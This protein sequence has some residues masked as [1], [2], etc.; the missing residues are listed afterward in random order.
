MQCVRQGVTQPEFGVFWTSKLKWRSSFCAFTVW[1]G[2]STTDAATVAGPASGD[3]NAPETAPGVAVQRSAAR[4][5]WVADDAHTWTCVPDD[6]PHECGR[7]RQ[8]DVL[9]CANMIDNTVHA[10]LNRGARKPMFRNG[11]RHCRTHH[12]PFDVPRADHPNWV[13]SVENVRKHLAQRTQQTSTDSQPTHDGLH[14][15]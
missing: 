13:H 10:L 14:P 8:R 12:D 11:Y 6:T 9:A 3:G 1:K 7:V 15:P 2:H 5:R 4:M